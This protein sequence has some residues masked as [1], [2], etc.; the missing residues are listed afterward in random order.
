V[1]PIPSLTDEESARLRASIQ[2]DGVIYPVLLDRAGDV[3]D[4]LH[5]KQLAEELG[6]PCPTKTIDV[7]HEAAERLRVTLN[8]ARRQLST[9][10]EYDMIAWLDERHRRDAEAE[11]RMLDPTG[12][13]KSAESQVRSTGLTR[14]DSGRSSRRPPRSVDV[15]AE[16]INQDLADLGQSKRITK[17]TV[18]RARRYAAAPAELKAK[19]QA[20][21]ISVRSVVDPHE[22]ARLRERKDQTRPTARQ[23]RRQVQ[24]KKS[25]DSQARIRINHAENLYRSMH[26]APL[27]KLNLPLLERV[28]KIQEFLN[29]IY[30]IK[31]RHAA[32]S[33]PIERCREFLVDRAAW[34]QEFVEMCDKRRQAETPDVPPVKPKRLIPLAERDL[35][36]ADRSVLDWMRTQNKPAAKIEVAVAVK[37]QESTV[38]KAM[39]K[40]VGAGLVNE[41]G[42]IDRRRLYQVAADPLFNYE[43]FATREAAD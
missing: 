26:N 38:D 17:S 19:V 28:E 6:V 37:L 36:P 40:L 27:G 32:L 31:P 2:Q 21:E 10:A 24:T 33:L 43:T 30:E 8:L 41:V 34:W 4:G 29:D 7:S 20:G 12:G 35:V 3:I 15:M 16:R 39:Q 1:L 23:R 5:R 13:G 14:A 9:A 22:E 42:R 18:A 11:W 25:L